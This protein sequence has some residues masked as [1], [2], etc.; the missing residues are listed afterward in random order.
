MSTYTISQIEAIANETRKKFGSNSKEKLNVVNIA[1][2]LGFIVYDACFKDRQI[3]GK[4]VDNKTTRA[5]YVNKDDIPARKRFTVAHE[6]GHI[7]L[8]HPLNEKPFEKID[9]RGANS[10]FDRKEWE[11]NRFAAALLMPK[12]ES[13]IIWEQTYDIDDFA[14]RMGVS[15]VAAAI[16][17]ETLGFIE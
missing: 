3:A 16:R 7:I 2:G 6:I 5:I 15:K 1:K 4:V 10:T 13:K 12:D 17:L 9:Y 11:A 8:H 14:D